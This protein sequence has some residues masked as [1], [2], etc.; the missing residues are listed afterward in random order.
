MSDPILVVRTGTHDDYEAVAAMQREIQ[1]A[2]W[3]AAPRYYQP[4]SPE[5]LTRATFDGWLADANRELVVVALAGRVV[6]YAWLILH[7]RAADNI[8]PA[9]RIVEI[10]QLCVTASE[11][12][13]GYGRRL[14]DEID[15]R[16]R[17]RKADTLELTAW[18]FNRDAIDV[19]EKHGFAPLW[20][21]MS[22]AL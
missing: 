22:R 11:R 1:E 3:Q 7:E 8:R 16:A 2:H 5:T 9:M 10:G 13:H 21:R 6:G 12:G 20:Q 17:A 18:L 15:A 4:P 14:L 19:Y